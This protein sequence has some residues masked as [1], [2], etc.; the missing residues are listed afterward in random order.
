MRVVIDCNVLIAAAIT[1]GTCRAVIQRVVERD[2]I[3]VS[4]PILEEYRD[5][6]MRPKYLKYQATA[7]SIISLL[8]SVMHQ[9]MPLEIVPVLP[10][11]QD[12]VYLATAL[13]AQAD[14]IITGNTKDF[15]PK[16]CAP[17]KILTPRQYLDDA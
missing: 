9:V 12:A 16:S 5:V 8:E 11:P 4:E 14:A 2:D 1:D 7:L 13:A 6:A 15:P 10:D 17:V 3:Y